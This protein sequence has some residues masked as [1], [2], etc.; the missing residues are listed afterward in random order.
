MRGRPLYEISRVEGH[1]YGNSPRFS[2]V[3]ELEVR[4][5]GIWGF[6][7]SDGGVDRGELQGCEGWQLTSLQHNSRAGGEQGQGLFAG[8]G[9]QMKRVGVGF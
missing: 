4:L 6:V 8:L 3:N 2:T 7:V 5:L 9:L 1:L